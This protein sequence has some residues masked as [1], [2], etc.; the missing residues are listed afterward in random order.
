MIF[1]DIPVRGDD[2]P[3]ARAGYYEHLATPQE[4]PAYDQAHYESVMT[5]IKLIYSLAKNEGMRIPH[6]TDDQCRNII[7]RLK[8][9]KAADIYG[10][11]A[12]HLQH[13]HP[14]VSVIIAYII[15]K[16]I[17][18]SEVL[19]TGIVTPVYK[20]KKSVLNPDNYRR[21]TVTALLCKVLEKVIIDPL[22]QSLKPKI[23]KLQRGFCEH[24]SS[25]N[26]AF[27]LSEAIAEAKDQNIALY[28]AFLDAS[29]A[30]DVVWHGGMLSSLHRLGVDGD[31][32]H[33]LSSLYKN[34][35]SQVK[36][37]SLISNAFEELQGVRQG[38]I[39]STEIFKAR[40]HQSL[41][42]LERSGQG[43]RIG[44]TDV[45]APTCADDITLIADTTI[46]LQR[47]L[48]IAEI[49]ALQERYNYNQTKSTVMIFGKPLHRNIW[50][51]NPVW[52]L[53]G[54]LLDV[55]EEETHLGI[56]RTPQG[57]IAQHVHENIKKARRSAYSMMSVG[58]FGLNGAHPTAGLKLWQTYCLPVLLFGLEGKR[59][60]SGNI[61]QLEGCQRRMLR[62][63]MHLPQSTAIHILSGLLPIKALL[64][65]QTLTQV[66]T[67][68]RDPSTKES[69]ILKRQAVMK[70][71]NSHSCVISVR[72]LLSTYNLP[73]IFD[74]IDNIP[75]QREWK[76]SVNCNVTNHW[77]DLIKEQA[78][79]MVTLKH[80][81][82]EGFRPK[83]MHPLWT[84]SD[85][86]R[87]GI[88]RS[89]NH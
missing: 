75:S 31:L 6:V 23:S 38:G 76:K 78:T 7:S 27:L 15:N 8:Q 79:T 33:I 60:T 35:S 53:N 24:S 47:M 3:N 83:S 56:I 61:D 59:L 37:N 71:A 14:N 12:E 41:V 1:D 58:M 88:I 87:I 84:T 67:F 62:N 51:A 17:D 77:T 5:Q 48:K 74:L 85:T 57:K 32:W 50:L 19:K 43:F 89:C 44:Q 40:G 11:S 36:H 10:L 68:L 72:E 73:T 65:K 9:R 22:K 29:K 28:V 86:T 13:A 30:F 55:S 81:Y 34:M 42:D 45:S 63:I 69:Q 64:D 16:I 70:G 49:D 39:P 18:A 66:V 46:G 80:L 20:K 21:I 4:N 82:I 25:A 54:Q 26:T 52:Q 2:L